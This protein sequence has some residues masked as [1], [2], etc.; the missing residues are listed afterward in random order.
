MFRKI[1]R[2]LRRASAV[3]QLHTWMLQKQNK[4]TNRRFNHSLER[5][6]G[7]QESTPQ[8][9]L[10]MY[11]ISVFLILFFICIVQSHV[12]NLWWYRG[13]EVGFL[14]GWVSFYPDT[15][16]RCWSRKEATRRRIKAGT[17]HCMKWWQSKGETM[18]SAQ[19][20]E[21]WE[22][23]N[24]SLVQLTGF[25]QGGKQLL[26]DIYRKMNR[27][28]SWKGPRLYLCLF[29]DANEEIMEHRFSQ[30]GFRCSFSSFLWFGAIWV[31]LHKS[32]TFHPHLATTVAL[33]SLVVLSDTHMDDHVT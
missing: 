21:V 13:V 23:M 27:Q 19:D 31:F 3:E 8:F 16:W 9:A 33:S 7:N 4:N 15:R 28:E 29:T 14:W 1:L 22:R 20:E 5:S 10:A 12:I 30:K 6:V 2:D 26:K 17:W 11:S 18:Q 32:A 25:L 24:L